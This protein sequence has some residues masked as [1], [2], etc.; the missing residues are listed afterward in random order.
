MKKRKISLETW[1]KM[2]E[3]LGGAEK[4]CSV[5]GHTAYSGLVRPSDIGGEIRVS[6]VR[7]LGML[8]R[9][10]VVDKKFVE[11]YKDRMEWLARHDVDEQVQTACQEEL[12]KLKK[13]SG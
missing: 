10:E 5:L 7:V 13:L 3:M 11:L 6:L 12:D 4:A 8:I 2:A 1:E 9:M